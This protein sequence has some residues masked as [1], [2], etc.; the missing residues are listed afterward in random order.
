MQFTSTL[1]MMLFAFLALFHLP[2]VLALPVANESV[3]QAEQAAQ[4]D[5]TNEQAAVDHRGRRGYGGG[6]GRGFY[7]GGFYGGGYYPQMYGYPGYYAPYY[8]PY[9]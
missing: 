1:L 7:G 4:A 3:Q 5:Q 2:G 6:W 8:P 9:Y